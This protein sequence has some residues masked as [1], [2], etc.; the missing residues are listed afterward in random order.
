MNG[1]TKVVALWRYAKREANNA[2]FVYQCSELINVAGEEAEEVCKFC[3]ATH[4]A[5]EVESGPTHTEIKYSNKGPRLIE[6]N[7]RWHGQNFVSICRQCIGYDAID[8]SLDCFFNP[9]KI[10]PPLNNTGIML[11]IFISY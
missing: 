10:L 7:A 5:L 2:P 8:L 6:V 4:E 1:V 3:L 11:L 9:S